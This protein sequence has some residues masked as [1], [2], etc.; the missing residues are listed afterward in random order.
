MADLDLSSLSNEQ[1]AAIAGVPLPA[2]VPTTIPTTTATPYFVDATGQGWNKDNSP[3]TAP[4][5]TTTPA[6]L[7]FSALSNEALAK[8]AG[9]ELPI[10]TSRTP[11]MDAVAGQVGKGAFRS[12][13]NELEGIE[14]AARQKI[15]GQ[16]NGRSFAEMYDQIRQQRAAED[17]AYQA[18]NPGTAIGLQMGGAMLPL[19]I[20]GVGAATTGGGLARAGGIGLLEGAVSG[21]GEMENNRLLGAGIGGTVGAVAAPV[22]KVA[23]DAGGALVRTGLDKVAES[24]AGQAILRDMASQRGSIS[25]APISSLTDALTPEEIFVARQL[26]NTNP[27]NISGGISTL[28]DTINEGVPVYLPEAVQSPQV[29]ANAKYIANSP[30]SREFAKTQIQERADEIGA[31]L[32]QTLGKISATDS[33]EGGSLR[34][35]NAAKNMF[36]DLEAARKEAVDPLY[37][38]ARAEAPEIKNLAVQK[39]IATDKNLR[40]A[41][42][43][44]KGYSGNYGKAETS[45]EIL[46]QAKGILDDKY[47]AAVAKGNGNQARLINETRKALTGQLEKASPSYKIANQTYAGLTK[48]IEELEQSFIG[49]IKD[50]GL[51]KITKVEELLNLQPEAVDR[52]RDQFVEAGKLDEWNAGVRA[53]IQNMVN[54]K[55]GAG[56]LSK[57]IGGKTAR[58]RLA[59]MLG[60]KPGSMTEDLANAAIKAFEYEDLMAQGTREYFAGSPTAPLMSEAKETVKQASRLRQLFTNSKEALIDYVTDDTPTEALTKGVAEIYFD[61]KRGL[62]TL[63]KIQPLLD[64]YGK[65]AA[66]VESGKA[67]IQSQVPRGTGTGAASLLSSAENDLSA[68]QPSK[69]V[70]KS[71]TQNNRSVSQS[72]Q[73]STMRGQTSGTSNPAATSLSQNSAKS[74]ISQAQ[75]LTGTS[76][77][78]NKASLPDPIPTPKATQQVLKSALEVEPVKPELPKQVRAVS[79]ATKKD[80]KALIEQ[81]EPL[82]QAVIRTESAGNPKATSKAGAT[83]L[84]QLMPDTARELKV[85]PTN[86]FE[87]VDGGTRYLKQMQNKYKDNALALAAYNAGPGNVDKAIARAKK[88]GL[89][90]TFSGIFKFL[91][92][93]TQNYVPTVARHYK[94]I[95]EV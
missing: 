4:V 67:A 47:Q 57:L 45:L 49:R 91:P 53:M 35:S 41:I 79:G 54:K 40:T 37:T 92:E 8:I 25:N 43:E 36:A 86:P 30:G 78:Q 90:A 61:P 50:L 48:P 15:T 73:A 23:L 85:D 46:H 55:D 12:W 21:A 32:G 76:Q 72:S 28:K 63:K 51:E 7:D 19:L 89:P 2:A 71:L 60:Q 39:L 95:V 75:D 66:L 44:V 34:M 22:A 56:F 29:F 62:S 11:L 82:I 31:R 81:Q 69:S 18:Q 64:R 94:D 27:Q 14:G 93:E 16:A 87:N 33:V 5:A 58:D 84:M 80:V 68:Q 13:F 77:L 20:P 3:Y 83:G 1:L 17:T 59:T 42:D 38:A 6:P 88:A 65:N 10:A 9:V 74:Q 70:S 24:R 52:L 26:K